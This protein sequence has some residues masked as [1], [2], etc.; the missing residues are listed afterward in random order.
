MS[1]YSI[2]SSPIGSSLSQ[3]GQDLETGLYGNSSEPSF[4]KERSPKTT[5]SKERSSES[6]FYKERSYDSMFSEERSSEPIFSKERSSE[7]MAYK[8]KSY[9]SA[10]S[11]PNNRSNETY[12][13]S[14]SNMSSQNPKK[15]QV[16]GIM[17]EIMGL[18]QKSA[19]R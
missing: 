19:R 12:T 14:S 9:D 13:T 10:F 1:S 3:V 6:A 5:F 18:V 2:R 4:S 8:E 11:T 7:P 15:S 17:D 16:H